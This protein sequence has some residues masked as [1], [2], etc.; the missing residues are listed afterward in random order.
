MRTILALFVLLLAM[1]IDAHA[2]QIIILAGPGTATAPVPA[3]NQRMREWTLPDAIFGARI[4]PALKWHYGQNCN[5]E[6]PPV[7]VDKTNVEA[8]DAWTASVEARLREIVR[9]YEMDQA[10]ATAQQG[11]VPLP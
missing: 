10:R 5:T 8:F 3:A 1:A 2:G 7:C 6:S 11:I 4:L 9:L